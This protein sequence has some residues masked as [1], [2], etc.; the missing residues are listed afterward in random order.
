MRARAGASVAALLLCS[1]AS[2]AQTLRETAR[3]P[4]PAPIDA[5]AISP[6]GERLAADGRDGSLRLL[7]TASGAVERTLEAGRADGVAFS[8]DGR[9]IAVGSPGGRVRLFSAASGK[10]EGEMSVGRGGF[11]GLAFSPDGSLLAVAPAGVPAELWEAAVPPRL[12]ARLTT[13]FSGSAA[14]AFSPDGTLLA[15]ADEDTRVRVYRADTGALQAAT[16]VSTLEPFAIAFTADGK[17]LAVGGADKAVTLLDPRTGKVLRRLAKQPDPVAGLLATP[18]GK[19]LLAAYF[20]EEGMSAPAPL[21]LWDL[22]TGEGRALT[23]A[24]SFVTAGVAGNRVLLASL[25][26]NEIVIWSVR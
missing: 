17:S 13:E 4:A 5:V 2:T 26:G 10:A 14:V 9:R 7:R 20:H 1:T 11:S 8:P 22:A 25:A 15:T 19:S 3:F 16:D 24:G 12:R 18:D 23:K 6:D 21:L